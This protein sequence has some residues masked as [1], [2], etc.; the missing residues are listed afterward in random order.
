MPLHKAHV[1]ATGTNGGLTLA[2][3]A[4]TLQNVNWQN[5]LTVVFGALTT[6]VSWY[7]SA[8][9]AKRE[10]DRLDREDARH[11][12]LEDIIQELRIRNYADDPRCVVPNVVNE[13]INSPA[14]TAE[15][16]P[17]LEAGGQCNV[18]ELASPPTGVHQNQP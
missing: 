16:L 7:V 9:Q 5:V 12:R 2:A 11:Q 18:P 1:I 15:P 3:I 13:L 17:S 10:Q 4:E 14:A 8:R 6:G